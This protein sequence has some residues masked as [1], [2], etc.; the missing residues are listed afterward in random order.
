MSSIARTVIV[1]RDEI[2][3]GALSPF[4]DC[5]AISSLRVENDKAALSNL[6]HICI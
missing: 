6:L 5:E 4:N 1:S 2:G 3:G